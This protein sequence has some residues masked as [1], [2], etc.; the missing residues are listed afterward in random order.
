MR[1]SEVISLLKIHSKERRNVRR[2][3]DHLL[4]KGIIVRVRKDR[5]VLPSE[6][7]LV[8][9]HIQMTEKGFGFLI[10]ESSLPH[11]PST[12]IFISAEDTWVAMHGDRVVV[13]IHEPSPQKKA[14]RIKQRSQRD[15][16]SGRV[17]RILERANPTLVGVLQ[18]SQHF[19]YVV[20]D[21]P[22]IN[23]DIY[24]NL[25]KSSLKP[26]IGDRLVVKLNA[27]ENRHINPEGTILEIIGRADDPSLDIIAIVKKFRLRTDF[28]EEVISEADQLD[29]SIS[30]SEWERRV[31]FTSEIVATI[32]PDDARDYDDALSLKRLDNGRWMLGVHIADVSH[33]IKPGSSLDHEARERGNSVYLPDRVIPMLPPQLSNEICS[34]KEGVHRLTQSVLFEIN[35]DGSIHSYTF[36]DTIIRSAARLTYK[37][38]L[39]VIQHTKT[40]KPPKYDSQKIIQ[41]P[42]IVQLLKNLWALASKVRTQRFIH[43]SLDL[44]FPELKVYCDSKGLAECIEK[45]ENDISH[46][47]VEEFM[48]LANEAVAAEIRRRTIP[49]IYRIHEDPDPEKLEQYRDLVLANGYSM[50]DP[51]LRGEIQKLLKRLANKPEEYI[52]KLALLR[53]LKRAQYS[54]NPVGHYGLAKENYTHFTSP[55]RRYADLIVHR[56]LIRA[57][58]HS[59]KSLSAKKTNTAYDVASLENISHHCSTTERIAAEA[60]K[61]AVRLKLIEY[62]EHQLKKHQLDS[63]EALV[64]E[65][66]NFGLFIELPDFMLSGLV[67]VSTLKD[68]FYHFDPVRQKLCGKRTG[69]LFQ[70][71][72][73]V[74]VEVARVDRFK[75]QVDFKLVED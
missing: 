41:D 15:Q 55:I 75:K 70:A 36:K 62:F 58:K 28:P 57:T 32:D 54:T 61:E 10:P 69:R 29:I 33:Y 24:M 68:D 65:V 66:R 64:T 26:K 51:T 72:A 53:S 45:Q 73:K 1:M 20:P 46:Q 12:D 59:R 21:D 60:E 50:G 38:V 8:T 49:A 37:Q 40:N 47:L 43:R 56:I 63:F 11:P 31:D 13:R 16:P 39:P 67:H 71:G 17:I 7:D 14:S 27:W 19:Y 5:L 74:Q 34:L 42:Q 52:L 23:R 6:A 22:R 4:Q 48:L 2:V 30:D 25:N 44:D 18:R 35:D 3:I 9:G